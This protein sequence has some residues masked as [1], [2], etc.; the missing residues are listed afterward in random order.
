MAN[1]ESDPGST[2]PTSPSEM[3]SRWKCGVDLTKYGSNTEELAGYTAWRIER[4]KNKITNPIEMVD[5]FV[6]DFEGW[7][8]H[9][10][11]TMGYDE[12]RDLRTLIRSKGVYLKT[13]RGKSIAREL[14]RLLEEDMPWP[15]EDP[16]NPLYMPADQNTAPAG[17]TPSREHEPTS[18]VTFS[19]PPVIQ[20]VRPT[21][22]PP[23]GRT[24]QNTSFLTERTRQGTP[25]TTL[26][27]GYGREI[28][29]LAKLISQ[30][31]KYSGESTDSF[32]F[33]YSIFQSIAEQSCLPDDPQALAKAL[34]LMLTGLAKDFYYKTCRGLSLEDTIVGIK[35]R[36]ETE[37]R[38]R[39][40][41]Q[42][43][44]DLSFQRT[45]E[46]A[47]P[48][49]SLTDSL[50]V[51][52]RGAS[53]L[54]RN[55]PLEYQSTT[56][57]RDKLIMACRDVEACRFA[58]YKPSPTVTGVIND[59]QAS[60]ATQSKSSNST[61]LTDRQYHD[62]RGPPRSPRPGPFRDRPSFTP[63]GSSDHP[64]RPG[65]PRRCF[66]CRKVGCW[67]SNHSDHE[68]TQAKRR[69]IQ[70]V[71]QLLGEEQEEDKHDDLE[72]EMDALA[73]E[74]DAT[75]MNHDS[76]TEPRE[77]DQFFLTTSSLVTLEQASTMATNLSDNIA[78][79][80]ITREVDIANPTTFL[81]M[82][83]GRYS[84]D[85]FYGVMIDT[86]AAK[87][88]T[89]GL[90]QFEAYCKEFGDQEDCRLDRKTSGSV[91]VRYGIGKTSSIGSVNIETPVGKVTFHVMD[92]DLPFLLSLW[93]MD[94]LGIHFNNIT[95][96][97]IHDDRDRKPPFPVI[98]LFDHPF[99]VW[100]TKMVSSFLTEPELRQLHRRFGHPSSDRLLRMMERAGHD[101]DHETH[102]LLLRRI[103]RFCHLCQKHRRSPGRFRFTIK[104][105][106][107]FNHVVYVDVMYI[108][109]DPVLHVVDEATRYQAARFLPNMTAQ[110]TWEALRLAWIDVYIGPP[111]MCVHDAGTNFTASEFQQNARAL[112]IQTKCVPVEAAQSM[113]RVER[114]HGPLRRAYQ[115]ISEEIRAP[116][117]LRLQ[118]A[119]K[120]INDTAGPDGLVP[121][122][123]VFGTYPRLTTDEIAPSIS[124]R[125][126]AV[127]RAMKEVSAIHAKRQINDALKARNGPDTLELHDHSMEPGSK[128]IVWRE[129]EKAWRGPYRLLKMDKETCTIELPSGPTQ[130]RSTSVKPFLSDEQETPPT[131]PPLKDHDSPTEKR[132]QRIRRPTEKARELAEHGGSA[133][134]PD[135]EILLGETEGFESSRQKEINGLLDRGVFEIVEA[136][137]AKG[138][139]IFKSRFVDNIKFA[140]TDRAFEK[141]RLVVQAYNDEDKSTI[142]TQSPTVQRASQR[143]LLSLGISMDLRICV[144]DIS[145]AYV[146]STSTINREIFVKPPKEL[147]LNNGEL[148]KVVRPLYGLPEAGT[149][150]YQ[151]YSRH[152]VEKLRMQQSTFDPCLLMTAGKQHS[153]DIQGD[154]EKRI[155]IVGMQVDDSLIAGTTKFL[156]DEE[157]ELKHAKLTAKPL[158]ELEIDNDLSFNGGQI[159]KH[160]GS[161]K[162][163]QEKQTQKIKLIEGKDVKAQYIA[164]RA[165]GAYIAANC[166]P[167][168]SFDF[169]FAAQ[170]TDPKEKEVKDLNKALQ[171]QKTT[172]RGLSFVKLDMSNTKI[173][174]FTDSS[175]ANNHD[176]SSQIGYVVTMVDGN[177]NAN[178]I[179]WSS[180]K[181]RR[182]TRSVLASELFALAL[183]FDAGAVIKSAT[184]KFLG[185][186]PIPLAV[187]VDSRSLYDCLVKLGT[188]TEKR[189]MVDIMALRQSYQRR[190]IA[191]VLCIE[192]GKN[193]ADAMTKARP[194]D[195]L[196][197]LINTNRLDMDA[198][199]W[200]TRA[201]GSE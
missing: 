18:R 103:E 189:L 75:D 110:T 141:S 78:K 84:A 4:Y 55:L 34:P 183:G 66:V 106:A 26:S 74:I 124:Q 43:W 12:M 40:L 187:A 195:A 60:I 19:A 39:Y 95:N 108:D 201:P 121:T 192:G 63:R 107:Q 46:K 97:V 137:E 99:M 175:F 142:L 104:D 176:L 7:Q 135:L 50:D 118:M 194:C 159:S 70:R 155:G 170:S 148:L 163:T 126:A 115:I 186:N 65:P 138:H 56:I 166:Q 42:Q 111:D 23:A 52:V 25:E 5:A 160:G 81:S 180:V 139:R 61:F 153:H 96:K 30:E 80:G 45:I 15:A 173:V 172:K 123:L 47:G 134:A 85:H 38:T 89:G 71:D 144:R 165:L 27:V 17:P 54:Q 64:P 174:V 73:L 198:I 191:E 90:A 29:V 88:S 2:V 136:E 145:Q 35:A 190:E 113:G 36:F 28:A 168:R 79:H 100:G 196:T 44:N 33:K 199:R 9:H 102:R 116:K 188:T 22:V 158:E 193:V 10:F 41:V 130:F 94:R 6:M 150:W 114:Y 164:Q 143:L 98:R 57:L 112:T 131:L 185:S 11:A 169:A 82:G 8:E 157:L 67:S 77:Q 151:T 93:D 62:R 120:A 140:G 101:H 16:E 20:P 197:R 161:I 132:P 156:K 37:E 69:V 1:P 181:C 92:A 149:H 24:R 53:S 117:P 200:V 105:D 184:D 68:K 178:V 177:G 129:H 59:L 152:H 125:A 128:I 127:K 76:E 182:I 146:Q 31:D 122:L 87:K 133:P 3:N 83:N 179:H 51:L 119:V 154:K 109:G 72:E 162:V 58:C 86:G 147:S 171:W 91:V 14:V 13:G 32:D 49:K 48:E 21:S 167:E